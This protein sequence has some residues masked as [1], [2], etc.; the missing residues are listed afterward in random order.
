M[1][2]PARPYQLWRLF[3]VNGETGHQSRIRENAGA[4]CL[5]AAAI[6]ELCARDE[7]LHGTEKGIT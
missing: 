6:G 3:K 5:A 7:R 1:V 2:G 4:L